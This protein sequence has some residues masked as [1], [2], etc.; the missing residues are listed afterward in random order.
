MKTDETIEWD[1][2]LTGLRERLDLALADRDNG[3]LTQ[4][5]FEDRLSDIE[6][7]LGTDRQLEQ[8][9]LR[10]GDTRFLVRCRCTGELIAAFQLRRR[11]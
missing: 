4:R 11:F 2:T 5:E 6:I 10:G 9:E 3:L 8:R 7:G 1:P